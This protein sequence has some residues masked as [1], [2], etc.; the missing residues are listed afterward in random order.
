MA[1]TIG[2]QS[3]ITVYYHQTAAGA[4]NDEYT[5]TRSGTVLNT[6]NVARATQVGGTYR[7]SRN[8]AAVVTAISDAMTAAADQT[9]TSAG[10]I[11]DASYAVIAGD[12][13]RFTTVG[14]ATLVDAAVVLLPPVTAGVTV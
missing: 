10:T 1:G 13:L 4:V 12:A 5:L 7:L 11:D 3:T 8:R 2:L 9:V 6:W 14:A